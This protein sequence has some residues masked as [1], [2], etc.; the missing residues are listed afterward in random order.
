MTTRA[1]SFPVSA[2]S[3][4]TVR[5]PLDD[6]E[7]AIEGWLLDCQVRQ[8][9]ARTIEGRRQICRDFV[10]F[11]RASGFATVGTIELRAFLAALPTLHVNSDPPRRP[12]GKSSARLYY[13]YLRTLLNWCV[14]EDLIPASPLAKVKPPEARPDQVAPFSDDE[15][16]KILNAART[17]RFPK[18]DEAM[19]LF[20]LD[21]GIRVGELVGLNLGDIDQTNRT[22]TVIGKGDKSRMVAYSTTCSKA[23][24]RYLHDTPRQ[25][26]DPVWLAAGGT[27]SHGA[28]T[29][30]GV[31]Q[32]VSD[33]CKAAG[34]DRHRRGPHTLRHTFA[35]T[36]LRLGGNVFSLQA[37]L[38]HTSLN[39][40]NIYVQFA[41]A[42][43]QSQSRKFSPADKL[44]K[45]ASLR[46]GQL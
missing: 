29:R 43:I 23:L 20:L 36:F 28:L 17:G 31:Y 13:A 9:S 33:L 32:I 8:H 25:P 24:W 42:D 10:A 19:I 41:N 18:R 21:T 11:T 6:L 14:D 26:H 44:G 35:V 39:A 30:S 46:N 27:N 45:R 5:I 1:P 7:Y 38:G 16:A 15:I 4:R 2:A 40:T 22:A 34:I 37:Q 3:G 12:I